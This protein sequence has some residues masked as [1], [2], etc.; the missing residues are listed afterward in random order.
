M[1]Q[2]IRQRIPRV[3]VRVRYACPRVQIPS[4]TTGDGTGGDGASEG[5]VFADEDFEVV[6][7]DVGAEE[8]A[9]GA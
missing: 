9:H 1:F 6:P 8:C 5:T 7:V 3:L 2:N 4:G